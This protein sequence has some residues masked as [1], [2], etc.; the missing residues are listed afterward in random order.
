[1]EKTGVTVGRHAFFL[2]YVRFHA[3]DGEEGG[4][5]K[6]PA[7]PILSLYLRA[8]IMRTNPHSSIYARNKGSQFFVAATKLGASRCT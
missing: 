3:R 7:F 2:T 6:G 5:V 8:H 1:M 4:G